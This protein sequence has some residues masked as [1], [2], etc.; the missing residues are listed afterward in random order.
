LRLAFVLWGGYIG[1]AESFTADLAREM[2]R[3][4]VKTGIVFVL[5]GEPL[6]RRLDSEGIPQVSLSLPRGRSVLLSPRRLA[7]AVHSM[8]SEAAILIQSGFLAATLRIG[9]YRAPIIA[10][11]HGA[12]LELDRL[13]PVRRFPG[14]IARASGARACSAIVAVSAYMADRLAQASGGPPIVC[15][16]NGVDLERFSPWANTPSAE[17]HS[18]IRVSCAARLIRGKGVDDLIR[19]FASPLLGSH[20]LRIAGTGSEREALESLTYGLGGDARIEFVGAVLDMPQFWRHSDV[21]VVPSNSVIES[22][23]MV[24]VEAMACGRPVIATRNGALPEIVVDGETG[25]LIEPGDIEG[26]RNA[27]VRYAADEEL[28]REHGRNARRRCEEKFNIERT[29]SRYIDLCKQIVR[30]EDH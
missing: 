18:E 23:G 14:V 29:A 15:I 10:V 1:G 25:Y 8:G 9:G 22:F 7:R 5:D 3:Q 11:E 24:A 12:L 2:N 19:A 21:A 20:R 6:A 28:R 30:A 16:H 27:L 26:L 13:P 17:T 4:G